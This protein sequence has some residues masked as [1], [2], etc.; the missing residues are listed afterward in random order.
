MRATL[1]RFSVMFL[2]LGVYS[3]AT[4]EW[5]YAVGFLTGFATFLAFALIAQH[6]AEVSGKVERERER[7]AEVF[8]RRSAWPVWKRRLFYGSLVGVILALMVW[9]LWTGVI[10]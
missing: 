4:A 2:A 1:L 3:G 6:E 5:T 9:K 8:A 10:R 7:Q